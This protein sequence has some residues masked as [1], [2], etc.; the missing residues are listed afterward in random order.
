MSEENYDVL[1]SCTPPELKNII[2]C[3]LSNLIPEK[4]K[5]QCEKCYS[6]FTDWCNKKNVKSE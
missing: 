3:A 6:D 2:N 4:S 5:R 1:V